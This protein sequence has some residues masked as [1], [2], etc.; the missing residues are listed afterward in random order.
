MDREV[1]NRAT[2]E[3]EHF[4]DKLGEIVLDATMEM[5][6]STSE[7]AKGVMNAF[8]ECNTPREFEIA[9]NM[10]MGICGYSFK[11]L[12]ERIKELDKDENHQWESI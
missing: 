4:R 12:I 3:I 11:S 7:M 9:N 6:N 1:L 5:D 2:T 8:S 10:L